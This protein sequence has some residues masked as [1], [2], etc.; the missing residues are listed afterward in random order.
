MK[1]TLLAL[2]VLGSFAGAAS[3]ASS[4]TLYGKVET[5]YQNQTKDNL[6]TTQGAAGESRLGFKGT[7]DLGNGM[8]A[9][10]QLEHKINADTG[11]N[12]GDFFEEKSIVGLSFANGAH[13]IYFGKSNSPIDRI[14]NNVGHLSTDIAVKSSM[15][16]W[17]NGAYYDYTSGAL[18]VGAAVTTKGGAAGNSST[19]ISSGTVTEGQSGTKSSYGAY[20]LYAPTNWSLGAAW[21]AD[22][23]NTGANVPS[24]YKAQLPDTFNVWGIKNE[25]LVTGSYTYKPVTFN[26]SYAA[27]KFYNDAKRKIWQASLVGQLT[28]NDKLF[29]NYNNIKTTSLGA[30]MEKQYQYGLGY[31]HSLS[32]RTEIFANVALVNSKAGL[33]TTVDSDGNTIAIP[34]SNDPIKYTKW[35]IGLRHSF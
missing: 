7:E 5:A 19:T 31:I 3:A 2:A 35:D 21:Q 11:A 26:A 22:N 15:G 24:A 28:S 27:A 10:F 32:K 20:V 16:G 1:Q 33:S 17:R 25:W 14:G 4:V 29:V 18:S 12:N 30:T 23:D 9:F 13:K 6:S 8:S 34:D